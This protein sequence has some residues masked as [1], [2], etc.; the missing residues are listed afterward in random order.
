MALTSSAQ[1]R[2]S[3]LLEAAIPPFPQSLPHYW[4]VDSL[5]LPRICQS[6]VALSYALEVLG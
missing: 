6:N 1:Q 4:K 2:I 5:S 3:L